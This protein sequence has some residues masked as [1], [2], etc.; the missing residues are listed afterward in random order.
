ME[1]QYILYNPYAGNG[2]GEANARV[3]E[4]IITDAELVFC[5]MTAINSYSEFFAGLE[6][7]DKVTVCGGDGT[8]NR[9]V[10][11]TAGIDFQRSIYYFP[12]FSTKF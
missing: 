2:R 7:N 3:L 6:P 10:N 5:D 12:A 1:K 8:L 4:N 9:F 11:E